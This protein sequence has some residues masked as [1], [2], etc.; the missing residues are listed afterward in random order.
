MNATYEEILVVLVKKDVRIGQLEKELA[1]EKEALA[2]AN[3]ELAQL[4][5]TGE[6]LDPI[7]P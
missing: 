6:G 4:R 7:R 3:T 5:P 1:A 2:A